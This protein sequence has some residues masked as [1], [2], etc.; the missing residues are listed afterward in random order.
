V[1]A[2]HSFDMVAGTQE[3]FRLLL[4]ALANPG[5]S[6]DLSAQI[7]QFSYDG[8]WLAPALTLLDNETAFYWDGS[9]ELGEEIRFLSGAAQVPLEKADFVFLSSLSAKT[10]SEAAKVLCQV[11]NGTHRDPHDSALIFTAAGGK[12]DQSVALKGPGIPPGGRNV[13]VSAEEA[14]WITARDAQGFEYP[15]GVEIIFLREDNSFLAITRKAAVT[16]PM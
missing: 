8:K 5:R 4:D 12:A 6:V 15:R 9:P 2:K 13:L 10:A 16:W 14:A 11:K 3:V 1:K 7:C